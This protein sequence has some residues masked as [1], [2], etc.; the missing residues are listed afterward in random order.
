MAEADCGPVAVEG[1][2]IRSFWRRVIEHDSG[3]QKDILAVFSWNG[4]CMDGDVTLS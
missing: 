3:S 2:G 1:Q 4:E